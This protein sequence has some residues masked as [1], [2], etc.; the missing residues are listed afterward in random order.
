MPSKLEITEQHG[1]KKSNEKTSQ[2]IELQSLPP[3]L[4]LPNATTDKTISHHHKDVANSPLPTR[5]TARSLP[6]VVE[7]M[8]RYDGQQCKVTTVLTA[9]DLS[10]LY[11]V[12]DYDGNYHEVPH[13][14][15]NPLNRRGT[16]LS[17]Q[18]PSH[19]SPDPAPQMMYHHTASNTDSNNT[20]PNIAPAAPNT[21]PTDLTAPA[22]PNNPVL[23]GSLAIPPLSGAAT[24]ARPPPHHTCNKFDGDQQSLSQTS[25]AD[26]VLLSNLEITKQHDNEKDVPKNK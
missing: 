8:V 12:E 24:H 2:N 3:F 7:S 23:Q 21:A 17:T 19:P 5:P 18:Q 22:T 4:V 25:T 13:N 15:L 9:D 20:D 10:F 6:F 14:E 26:P 16:P 1:S 11:M